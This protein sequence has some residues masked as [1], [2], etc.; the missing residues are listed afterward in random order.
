MISVR[1]SNERGHVDHG[2]LDAYHTFSFSDYFDENLMGFRALRVINEDRVQPG[3]GFGEHAHQDMEI[4]TYVLEGALEHKDSLGN[5]S[6]IRPGDVQRMSVGKG[7]MHSEFNPSSSDLLHLLQIWMIP[8][9]LDLSPGY[10]QQTFSAKDRADCWCLIASHDGHDGSVS[11]HQNVA[12]YTTLLSQHTELTHTL[13]P[14]RHAW[15]H[16]ARGQAV[17]DEHTLS[18]GDGVA[19]SPDS[20]VEIDQMGPIPITLTAQQPSE[21][22]LFDLD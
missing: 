11:V 3:Q 16:V 15:I 17:L 5:G 1:P 9:T 12:V 20:R 10:E 19:V 13:A 2:W 22:L 14:A 21:V 18:A 6:T 7:I 4:L 8:D